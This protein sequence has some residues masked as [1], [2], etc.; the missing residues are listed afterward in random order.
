LPACNERVPLS[1]AD[2]EARKQQ[3]EPILAAGHTLTSPPAA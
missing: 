2:Y 1:A 3:G